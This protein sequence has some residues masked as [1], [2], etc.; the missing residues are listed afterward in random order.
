[1]ASPGEERFA[2]AIAAKQSRLAVVW[3]DHVT[4]RPRGSCAKQAVKP[5]RR[6]TGPREGSSSASTTLKGFD[7]SLPNPESILQIP[8]QPSSTVPR[9]PGVHLTE[10]PK[11]VSRVT[12]AAG[13]R[14]SMMMF[15]G[16][17]QEPS[18]RHVASRYSPH[19]RNHPMTAAP[20]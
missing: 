12:K 5:K 10:R 7:D 6:Q 1:V 2:A 3:P 16:P 20:N 18:R 4:K 11:G 15:A 19:D 14:R 17:R 9:V 13:F 8:G